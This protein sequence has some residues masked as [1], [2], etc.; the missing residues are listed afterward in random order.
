MGWS[1]NA[2]PKCGSATIAW[3][4]RAMTT[5]CTPAIA[6]A[7]L[8]SMRLIFPCETVLRKILPYSMPGSFR[9]W[10]YSARPVTLSQDSRRGIARPT[11]GVSVGLLARFIDRPREI[12]SQQL[13][14][15]SRRAVQVA[16]DADFCGRGLACLLQELCIGI[17]SSQDFF[18]TQQA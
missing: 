5:R 16:L 14:F 8:T 7:A 10:T 17:F 12:D 2:G 6:C 9:L 18:G 1:W 3:R 4:S 13:F 11:W 15:V